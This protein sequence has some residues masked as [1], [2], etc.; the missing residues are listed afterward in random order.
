MKKNLKPIG[1]ANEDGGTG[2]GAKLVRETIFAE[3]QTMDVPVTVESRLDTK[4]ECAKKAVEVFQL[5][6][7]G[8]K[9]STAS[10]DKR[11]RA[12][13]LKSLNII[14][15]PLAGGFGMLRVLQGP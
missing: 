4:D 5:C 10:N 6:G 12:A 9:N 3:F 8:F 14:M 15:R 1:F 13:G 2:R 7:A 11:I